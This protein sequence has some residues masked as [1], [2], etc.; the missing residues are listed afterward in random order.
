M[1]YQAIQYQPTAGLVSIHS[2]AR[3]L[4]TNQIT[5]EG[6]SSIG[7]MSGP[8]YNYAVGVVVPAVIMIIM[9]VIWL[10]SLCCAKLCCKGTCS[11]NVALLSFNVACVLSIIF[12]AVALGGNVNT[13]KGFNAMLDGVG[14]VQDLATKVSTLSKDT[15]NF[16]SNMLFL[17]QD[18]NV[19]CANPN[20]SFP[21][22]GII[23]GLQ[24]SLQA[25]NG[26][27]GGVVGTMDGYNNLINSYKSL[28]QQYIQWREVGTMI[29]IIVTMVILTMFMVSTTLRVLDSTPEACRPCARCSSRGT[30]CV[31]FL[32][33]I[34][35]LLIIWIFVAIIHVI[36]TIGADMCV[37]SPSANI[38]RL[39]FEVINNTFG[40]VG[41]P[42]ESASFRDS[43]A[44][45]I[46]YYQTCNGT[47][48]LGDL[49]SPIS[50][51]TQF[52]QD[53]LDNFRTQLN[54]TITQFNVTVNA[55]CFESM[56]RFVNSTGAI[57]GIVDR[58]LNI[59]TCPE[60]NPVYAAF[61]YSGFCNGLID[62][63][64]LTYA[65]CIVAMVF[66][67]LAM[68]IFR[69]FDFQLYEYGRLP[70][71]FYEDPKSPASGGPITQAV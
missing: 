20:V 65:A 61:L 52:S 51:N 37:P 31:V 53:Q 3:L 23:D 57:N 40:Q 32:F 18:M 56:D 4:G 62:G 33:G 66:A 39:A 10:I 2:T 46:C 63:L 69:I 71:G 41:D 30:S 13:T 58:A 55:T 24:G 38:N 12:W 67:M 17:A 50:N 59:T 45:I 11:K 60:I 7:Q 44:G 48:K 29:V 27:G 26:S 6:A 64:T 36:V 15:T 28:I 34:L 70:E 54:D 19:S 5:T 21:F 68:S 43:S 42:C 49:L 1:A 14:A 35:L 8:L 16:T 22:D 47:N 9:F 25:V